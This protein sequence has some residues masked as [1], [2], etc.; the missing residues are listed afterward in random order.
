MRR[1]LLSAALLALLVV[2][3]TVSVVAADQIDDDTRRIGKQLQC[4]VCNGSPVS[5]SPSDLAGQMRSVIRAK[6][7][8]GESEQEIIGYFVER[9]GDMV[10]MEPPRRGF[11]LIVW[12]V[13]IVVLLAS[14]AL[15]AR[16][17]QGWLRRRR[18]AALLVATGPVAR[19]VQNGTAHGG[20]AAAQVSASDRARAELEQFK[21]RA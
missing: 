7:Q 19:P 18:T 3:A 16:V 1:Q 4:P 17:S 10:L 2:T 20:G 14:A 21:R 9:Y 11:G 12:S 8:A 6:L 15:L 5:D 13:P